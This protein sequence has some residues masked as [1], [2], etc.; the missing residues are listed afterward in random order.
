LKAAQDLGAAVRVPSERLVFRGLPSAAAVPLELP[1]IAAKAGLRGLARSFRRM[2]HRAGVP[3][4][5]HLVS[6]FGFLPRRGSFVQDLVRLI[7]TLDGGVTELMVHPAHPD[8]GVLA[9]WGTRRL[10]RER[11]LELRA[12]VDDRFTDAL[13]AGGIVVTTYAALCSPR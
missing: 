2:S 1:T 9:L 6:I 7:D 12:L 3:A 13:K 5:D 10:V 11:E 4:N 8:P